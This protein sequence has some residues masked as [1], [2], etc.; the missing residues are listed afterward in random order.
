MPNRPET[1]EADAAAAKAR[2]AKAEA[3]WT[4]LIERSKRLT[5]QWRHQ[6]ADDSLN[7]LDPNVITKV[8][9]EVA[10]TV[11]ADTGRVMETQAQLVHDITNLWRATQAA[12]AGKPAEPV[13]E[14]APD[15]RRFKDEAWT[16]DPLFAAVKQYYLLMSRWLDTLVRGAEGLDAQTR[17]K[18]LFYLRQMTSAMAPTNF[19]PTNPKVLR[20]IEESD[21]ATLRKGFGNLLDDMERGRGRLRISLTQADAFELGRDLAVTPGKVVFQNELAQIIQY[22]PSTDQVLRRPLLIV[23]PWINKYYVLDLQ[24]KNS[25]IR[26]AVDQGQTVFVISWVNPDPPLG[27]KSF[28]DY[29]LEGPLTALD[30]IRETTGEREVNALGYCIG[31][32]L[33]ASTLAHLAAKKDDRVHSATFFTTM[34][35]FAEPGEIGVFIDDE[36]IGLLEKH[37]D[38][39]GYLD[40]AS[41]AQ[42]F[43]MLRE[44]DLIWSSFVNNYLLG[45]SPP[46]FD[47]LYWNADTTRMPVAMHSFYLREMYLGNRLVKPDALTIAGT[48]IDLG[49]ITRP[50]YILATRE[51]HIAPWRST[52]AATQ[53]YKGPV[54]FVLAGSGHI[55]GVINPPAAG[56]YGYWLNPRRT[57]SSDAWLKGA[58]RMDGS[59]W[60]DWAAWI[61]RHGGG[62]VPA[63]TPGGGRLPPIEDAPGSYVRVRHAD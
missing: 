39:R 63:R 1:A 55:A 25:F 13:I 61:V 18:A 7:I 57:R 54:R 37:M 56:K 32:T 43:S 14:P 22:A 30:V 20:A 44:N 3:E 12:I 4:A 28:D 60:T 42:V 46:P 26:W 2:A 16:A 15:D 17:R 36:Q 27:E 29:L 45:K 38:A 11:F 47:I 59:W 21:G 48:P 35:D 53:L 34:V 5:E 24:P 31:G 19:I 50:A 8:F 40:G 41:M 58:K 33:L 9:V 52:F 62:R 49:R 23:P 51:D 6:P 10:K